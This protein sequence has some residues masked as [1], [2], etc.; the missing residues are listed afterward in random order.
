M[1]FL[2]C[3][4]EIKWNPGKCLTQKVLRKKPKNGSKNYKPITK[5][6]NCTSFFNFFNPPQI[7]EDDESLD[8]DAV[9]LKG[10]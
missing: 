9:S 4:T 3:R 6:E 8:D 5:T 7:P 2:L 1:L 10:F